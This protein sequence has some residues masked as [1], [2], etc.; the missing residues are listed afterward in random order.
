V[1][2]GQKAVLLVDGTV[3]SRAA[4]SGV[5]LAE[6]RVAPTVSDSV[7]KTVAQW[8]AAKAGM[9]AARRV[10]WKAEYWAAQKEVQRV[11][12]KEKR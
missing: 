10:A 4:Q 9:W 2:A 6:L 8:A 5:N 7:A 12:L 3:A 1:K 11:A